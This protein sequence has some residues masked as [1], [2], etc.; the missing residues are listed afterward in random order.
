MV[1][2]LT[3]STSFSRKPKKLWPISYERRA[4]IGSLSCFFVCLFSYGV[5]TM[6]TSV[7]RRAGEWWDRRVESEKNPTHAEAA[8]WVMAKWLAGRWT[9][10]GK[11]E[12][13]E[14]R[15]IAFVFV[16]LHQV[17]H[18]ILN[19]CIFLLCA[20]VAYVC[21]RVRTRTVAVHT[22][23]VRHGTECPRRLVLCTAGCL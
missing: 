13:V 7:V 1:K 4:A 23:G 9:P 21:V 5:W 15:D 11:C 6:R 3:F 14:N 17:P 19:M 10:Q 22:A 2:S 16:C 20:R 18:F 8:C 12:C